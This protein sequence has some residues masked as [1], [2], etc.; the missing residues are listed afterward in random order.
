MS[1]QIG[2]KNFSIAILE[3]DD[4]T[5]VKYGAVQKLE[6]SVSGKI[7]PKSNSENIYSDDELEDIAINFSLVD[8][9]IELSSLSI[10]SRAKLFGSKY[11]N[12][13]LIENKDDVTV[14]PYMAIIFKSK[15]L[16][17]SYRYVC[18]LK[19]KWELPEDD[20]ET[21]QD[22]IKT[23]TGK[24]KGSFISRVFDG[25]YKLIADGDDSNSNAQDL[26]KWFTV[27]PIV[28][29]KSDSTTISVVAGKE[30]IVTNVSEKILTVASGTTV[31]TLIS[32]I[33]VDGGKGTFKVYADNTKVTEATGASSVTASMVIEAIAEDTNTKNTYT[34]TVAS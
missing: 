28:P 23:G 5:G 27:V 16:N 24:L 4:E 26:E 30:T 11:I 25:N 15:K 32:A 8:V 6:R 18:L 19:G 20:Y 10:P 14:A 13:I 31:S 12:G 22:K 34:I 9:E 2:L 7:A 29:T 33:Q 17:G 3:Q 21:V 1:R